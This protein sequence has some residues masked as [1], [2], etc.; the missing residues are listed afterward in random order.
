MGWGYISNASGGIYESQES[1]ASWYYQHI[2]GSSQQHFY[3][4]MLMARGGV[5]GY[6]STSSGTVSFHI[7]K[8]W[9]KGVDN[10]NYLRPDNN[11]SSTYALR[12]SF[13][14][15]NSNFDGSSLKWVDYNPHADK[16]YAC[17]WDDS[18]GGFVMM[19]M[20]GPKLEALFKSHQSTA[21]TTS[22]ASIAAAVAGLGDLNPFTDITHLMPSGWDRT[23]NNWRMSPTYRVADRLWYVNEGSSENPL[24]ANNHGW[25]T[26]DFRTWTEVTGTSYF[27]QV[28]DTD[29]SVFSDADSTDKRVGN[30]NAVANSGRLETDVT[31][32]EIERTGLVLS[33]NDKLYVENGGSVDLNI[34]VMG[35]GRVL[36]AE[37]SK[38]S[39]AVSGTGLSTS[40][41]NALIEAKSKWEFIKKIEINTS[42]NSLEL[43]DGIDSTKYNSYLYEFEDLRPSSGQLPYWRIKN[44]NGANHDVTSF[45]HRHSTSYTYTT[46]SNQAQFYSNGSNQ[47]STTDRVNIQVEISD[48]EN[49][50]YGYIKTSM[51]TVGGYWYQHTDGNFV[52]DKNNITPS[53]YGSLVYL[54]GLQSGSVRIYGKRARSA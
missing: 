32:S 6:G 7:Y 26:S 37:F 11:T 9:K 31:F 51:S 2:G 25:I 29:T 24:S 42:V 14:S 41:V 35:F 4:T 19:E 10:A 5:C 21:Q 30:F 3:R 43:S 8:G 53:D 38:R 15:S 33:N 45:N 27:S 12:I 49:K 40:D 16:V 34:Q 18:G 1:S 46:A 20:D 17:F 28:I 48:V 52:I 23:N 22:Y 39:V 50:I 13:T 54:N 36:R 44:S 47:F